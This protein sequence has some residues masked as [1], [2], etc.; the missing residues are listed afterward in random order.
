MI[1]SRVSRT[2][3]QVMSD[4]VAWYTRYITGPSVHAREISKA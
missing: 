4:G 2:N 1:D 3:P